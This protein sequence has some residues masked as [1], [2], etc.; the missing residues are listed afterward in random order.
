MVV[1]VRPS[2]GLSQIRTGGQPGGFWPLS[3][4]FSSSASGSAPLSARQRKQVYNAHVSH[5]SDGGALVAPSGEV[6]P[7]IYDAAHQNRLL[8]SVEAS[9]RHS[10][11]SRS[12]PAQVLLPNPR[13][14][15]VTMNAGHGLVLPQSTETPSVP[16]SE[17][18]FRSASMCDVSRKGYAA[19]SPSAAKEN[20][21]CSGANL[22]PAFGASQ[23]SS[24]EYPMSP[25]FSVGAPMS[26][27]DDLKNSTDALH[28]IP[29]AADDG[30]IP[31]AFCELSTQLR[32]LDHRDQFCSPRRM[33]SSPAGAAARKQLNLSSGDMDDIFGRCDRSSPSLFPQWPSTPHQKDLLQDD[34]KECMKDPSTGVASYAALVEVCAKGQ[35]STRDAISKVNAS[36]PNANQRKSRGLEVSPDSPF[37]RSRRASRS[38]SSSPAKPARKMLELEATIRHS[39]N[40]ELLFMQQSGAESPRQPNNFADI[41]LGSGGLKRTRSLGAR[42][43]FADT[44][45]SDLLDTRAELSRSRA[46]WASPRQRSEKNFS[47]LFDLHLPERLTNLER[48]KSPELTVREEERSCWV[49]SRIGMEMNAEIARRLKARMLVKSG[50]MSPPKDSLSASERK[51][52]DMSSG[53][54]RRGIGD[55]PREWDDGR[56]GPGVAPKAP[57][58]RMRSMPDSAS[59]RQQSPNAARERYMRSVLTS[60][61]F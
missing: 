16:L 23:E 56:L 2:S 25:R 35:D 8:R 52:L 57:T 54:F 60:D 28:V 51:R 1:C 55:N 30:A 42:S 11:P 18:R 10:L 49:S 3:P 44:A 27:R 20:R 26:P 9:R 21:N 38:L 58:M 37:P 34:V 47:D 50:A 5:F 36:S 12:L 24:A 19:S 7:V 45:N 43:E 40:Q 32:Y 31:R 4:Q 29:A 46:G 6:A 33:Y 48:A 17:L 14:L 39:M 15:R 13:D 59:F 53:S 61:I 41:I 22:S